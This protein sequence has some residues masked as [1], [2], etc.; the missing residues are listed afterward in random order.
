ML[1]LL[2]LS[3]ALHYIIIFLLL[4][5]FILGLLYFASS[6]KMIKFKKEI[7]YYA[8]IVNSLL[9]AVA[10]TIE[11]GFDINWYTALAM[12]FFFVFG[13]YLLMKSDDEDKKSSESDD[14]NESI[15]ECKSS[16]E[17]H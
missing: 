2:N 1:I 7:L 9:L 13:I 5:I 12:T 17:N 6:L 8:I 14:N 16:D 11:I 3:L 4:S 10:A 15:N